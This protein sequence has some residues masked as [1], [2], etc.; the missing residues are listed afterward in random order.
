[1]IEQYYPTLPKLELNCRGPG[2]PGWK[3]WGNEAKAPISVEAT[4]P[5]ASDAADVPARSVRASSA[6]P[7]QD[8][9]DIPDCLRIGHADCWRSALE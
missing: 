1:M 3:V 2:R 9:L 5:I 7:P 4:A 6:A 8:T